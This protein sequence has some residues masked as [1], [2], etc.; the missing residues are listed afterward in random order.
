MTQVAAA[1]TKRRTALGWSKRRLAR[2]S[3]ISAP[4]LVQIEKGER[5][6]TPRTI[7]RIAD[8]L[9]IHPYVL[10]GE[11]GVIPSEL[12]EEAERV[13]AKALDD[14]SIHARRTD[15]TGGG[16]AWLVADYLNMLGQDAYGTETDGPLLVDV[17]WSQL[18]P[19]RWDSMRAGKVNAQTTTDL[20]AEAREWMKA[21]SS[22]PT[23]IEGWDE[24]TDT[25][26][27]LVQQL[28][29]QMRRSPR[30]TGGDNGDGEA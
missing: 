15:D 8:G 27:R 23:P 9:R 18:A 10:L 30:T 6:P 16:F 14:P 4:Y 24:L 28:V 5:I 13:A 3:G 20:L 11:S 26:R 12:V 21:N 7:A 17:D 1:V 2:E 22:P 19:H 25:Q 29:N